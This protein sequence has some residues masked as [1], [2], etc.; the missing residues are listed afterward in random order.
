MANLKSKLLQ[1]L[2]KS[3]YPYA[4]KTY[5]FDRDAKIHYVNDVDNAE[6]PF[7][8]TAFYN[9]QTSEVT[10]YTT[11]RHI[12]D[13][14]RSVS[15]E[16]VHHAQNCRGAFNGAANVGEQ[17]YAQND[18][19]LREMERE[20]YEQGN[21]C[22]R[23]W[24]DTVKAQI[25]PGT[26]YEGS[27]LYGHKHTRLNER[28]MK[29]W[30]FLNEYSRPGR[31]P[32]GP[33]KPVEMGSGFPNME[34]W[35]NEDPQEVMS[36][37][38]WLQGQ[39]PP[40]D[41]DKLAQAWDSL[42]KQLSKKHPPQGEVQS[43]QV[44]KELEDDDSLGN[45][46]YS[47]QRFEETINP[48]P[49]VAKEKL[50]K[51][52]LVENKN[53]FIRQEETKMS[54]INTQIAKE[55]V[56]RL[57]EAGVD[58]LDPSVIKVL[59]EASKPVDGTRIEHLRWVAKNLSEADALFE[60]EKVLISQEQA[61]ELVNVYD[62][63]NETNQARFNN[64]TVSKLLNFIGSS[65]IQE[66]DGDE[67]EPQGDLSPAQKE[68]DLDDDGKIEPSDLA[69]LRGGKEDEDVGDEAEEEKK[70]ESLRRKVEE[71]VLAALAEGKKYKR[72][73]DKPEEEEAKAEEAEE[74][75]EEVN[76]NWQDD[77]MGG[78]S[79]GDSDEGGN[80]LKMTIEDS[81]DAL[82]SQGVPLDPSKLAEMVMQ[83]PGIEDNYDIDDV[84]AAL[85]EFGVVEGQTVEDQYSRRANS[86][87]ERLMRQW[88]GNK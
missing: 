46:F 43:V 39:I 83:Q 8:K 64:A 23:D 65:M 40:S 78:M 12:K 21:L 54:N 41:P 18:S 4:K 34:E 10:V 9:P 86:L 68:L 55:I 27:D 62:S 48:A 63:L 31:E 37:V 69:G 7:G 30:G 49:Q 3:F 15:H 20:A 66:D 82:S 61:Q 29:S 16:L 33:G 88:F 14:M 72:D 28:L 11:G 38:Y 56:N 73:D 85:S 76:E 32:D 36:F 81:I 44:M 70:E 84:L 26:I 19:H 24:E 58:L 51:G 79:A 2:T 53:L 71:M 74:K 80:L 5:G 50:K 47:Q 75:E 77:P 45:K 6:K 42:V 60:L 67:D 17:G 13:I 35:W 52:L 59:K 57:Q 87:N 25:Q 22:F 1:K